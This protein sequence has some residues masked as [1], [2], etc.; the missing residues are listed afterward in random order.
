MTSATLRRVASVAAQPQDQGRPL[1]GLDV[2][3]DE[4]R[5]R[6]VAS[7][8]PSAGES[9]G[10]VADLGAARCATSAAKCCRQGAWRRHRP[11]RGRATVSRATA[12]GPLPR[13]AQPLSARP[14]RP[15]SAAGRSAAG[16]G[17]AT[18]RSG[19]PRAGS[20]ASTRAC[21][22]R[23]PAPGS[24]P[25]SSESVVRARS[26]APS[27]SPWRPLAVEREHEHLPEP[28]AVGD[29]HRRA[30]RARGRTRRRGPGRAPRRA[31]P[32]WP[33]AE[34][35]EPAR[36]GLGEA[37]GR[38]RRMPARAIA[39]V[40]H[41]GSA[42]AVRPAV[43]EGPLADLAR[44]VNRS[45]STAG[46]Q[47]Q[48]VA[49]AVGEQDCR[50]PCRCGSSALRSRRTKVCT[51]LAA[52]AGGSSSHSVSMSSLVVT[53]R[54]EAATSRARSRRSLPHGSRSGR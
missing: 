46:V 21:S 5:E 22:D 30:A 48:P 33:P 19:C 35:L 50:S 11:A 15:T 49:R 1:R 43:L 23:R 9:A 54:P 36:L 25:S 14:S 41:R 12:Q 28:L 45:A 53:S 52:L 42:R 31:G 4:E 6:P 3:G 24:T 13:L 10:L 40:P 44:R 51:D 16:G 8:A 37:A 47:G 34:L 39:P 18:V 17:E 7:W 29:G 2:V 38:T 32:R 26:Y 27:A 20:C